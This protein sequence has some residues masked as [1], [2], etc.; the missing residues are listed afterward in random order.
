[1]ATYTVITQYQITQA[2][3]SRYQNQCVRIG[4]TSA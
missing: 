4:V 3:A 2:A 1:M